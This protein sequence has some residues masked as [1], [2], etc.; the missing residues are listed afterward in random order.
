MSAWQCAG[1]DRPKGPPYRGVPEGDFR[2]TWTRSRGRVGAPEEV[3][4]GPAVPLCGAGPWNA[5]R[6]CDRLRRPRLLQ[7]VDL[8]D[9][10]FAGGLDSDLVE[11]R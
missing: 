6:R 5:A 11:H 8:E 2:A 3:P 1:M 10:R 4:Y 9:F 7:F